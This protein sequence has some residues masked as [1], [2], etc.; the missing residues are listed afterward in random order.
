MS[1]VFGE[2]SSGIMSLWY[3]LP[4]ALRKKGLDGHDLEVGDV[5]SAL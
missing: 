1:D 2:G 3:G 4:D 5:S